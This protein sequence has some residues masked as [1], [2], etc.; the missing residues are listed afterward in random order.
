MRDFP[1]AVTNFDD[2]LL[3]HVL[4]GLKN[5]VNLR[6]CTWTRDGS[7]NSNILEAL[8][9]CKNLQDLELNGH[10]IGNY[11]PQLLLRFTELHRISLIMP[12]VPVIC[13]LKPWLSATG[14]TLRSLFLAC[15]VRL[16][17]AIT[18]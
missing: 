7:L 3:R 2:N 8:H 16:E 10:N 1:K 6:S 11:D 4:N 15:E 13:Q 18:V 17:L 9:Q 12:S 14:A 5:C